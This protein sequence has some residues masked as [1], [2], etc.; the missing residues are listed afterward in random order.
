MCSLCSREHCSCG[1]RGWK[2]CLGCPQ[3][4]VFPSFVVL[5]ELRAAP[6]AAGGSGSARMELLAA[7]V[8]SLGARLWGNQEYFMHDRHLPLADQ[9][10]S[11]V[12]RANTV[13]SFLAA[14]PCPLLLLWDIAGGAATL[15][16]SGGL[17][18]LCVQAGKGPEIQSTLA[19]RQQRQ[20]RVRR[21]RQT[22]LKCCS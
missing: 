20:Q 13:C 16:N 18:I 19:L 2:G 14:P 8:C 15:W 21:R 17:N 12:F 9:A 3:Q 10:V 4:P 11:M 6:D 5:G 7:L 1:V 22:V